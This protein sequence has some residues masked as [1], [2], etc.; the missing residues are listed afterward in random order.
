MD[1]KE[2]YN[3]W[4]ENPY[5]D[6]ATK[7]ELKAIK[8]DENE[9]KERFYMD[10]E[11]GTAGLR[12]I[13]GAGTN[14]M[15]IYVVRRA[16]QGLAN[17]IAKVD[18]K[19]QGVAI[20]YDSRHMSPE[21]AQEAALCLAANGIKAYIFETLRPTPELSFAVRHLGCVAGINVTASHNPPEYNGYKVYW[22][23]GA[24]ITPPHDTGIMGEVKAIS[25]WNTV[26]TM[27]KEEAVKAGLFEVIG[28]AVDDAYMAELKKQIIHMDAIQAEGKN[29]KIVYTPLHGT[30][31]IPARRILKELGFENVYVVPEQELPD[32]DFPTVSYP[33]PEAAE[34][35]ELGL[36]LA[37][38]VDA[39]IVLATDPDADR[40]GVRVKDRNGEYHDLTGN[41]SGCLLANY[42]LSQRK[43][44]NGSLPEDGALVKTIVTTN[45]ADAIAKG[46]GVNLIEV[47]T[48]FKYIGQQ[49]LGFE[50]SGKGTYLFGFEESYGCLIGTYARD[51]DAIVATMALCEAAAYYKTQGKTLWDAMIDMYEEFGYYKDAIQAVT[52]KGIEGLQKIQEIMTTLRQNPP[53]EFA[54]HKV[55]AVRDYK[56]DEITDLA[57][58]EKKPTGLPNSNVLYYELTDDAW[59][60]VRPS[61]T[62]PKV[63]FYYGVKGTSLADADE[64]SDAMGK[65]VLEMVDSMK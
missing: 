35:F 12:G 31:N 42:E 32:G 45:L 6:E 56:L 40:L 15:N 14:R 26:K 64:K 59:V 1:Y 2:I 51:K 54:G 65:A 13:I 34:A 37:R 41:M 19:S 55:T 57:T 53:A 61:G 4:L 20:A 17:Y 24:Q 11:F 25:D 44:V 43:A 30:G 50:N 39:D 3:Q 58:G 23:D 38:E 5:F 8:D 52:M 27:D 47:L 9:I 29:L 63:K 7:E 49:I 22:E 60:C 10:L 48:G 18:K 46:Y 28:Q 36:K 62:E 21:F 16:T 33:N